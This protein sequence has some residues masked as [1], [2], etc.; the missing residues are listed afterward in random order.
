ML[1]FSDITELIFFLLDEKNK[2]KLA[3]RSKLKPLPQVLW[4][5]STSYEN[6]NVEAKAKGA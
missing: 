2:A 4:Q 3:S 1:V 6:D 5:T